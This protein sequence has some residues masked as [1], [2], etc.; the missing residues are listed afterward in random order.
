MCLKKW[1][2]NSYL[3]FLCEENC[4]FLEL[5]WNVILHQGT[6]IM[7]EN[8]LYFNQNQTMELIVLSRGLEARQIITYNVTL[9]SN[10]PFKNTSRFPKRKR[11]E[12]WHPIPYNI[13]ALVKS[14][15]WNKVQFQTYPLTHKIYL[16]GD[17]RLELHYHD[18]TLLTNDWPDRTSSS[19]IRLCPSR[20]SSYR[21]FTCFRT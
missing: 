11:L 6:E 8:S 3:H 7:Y 15:R 20:R 2:L 9:C 10:L 1:T 18:N 21:S 16:R 5:P 19:E 4:T 14:I 17:N 13:W 12:N